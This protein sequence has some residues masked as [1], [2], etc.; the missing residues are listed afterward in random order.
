MTRLIICFLVFIFFCG[1]KNE[2]TLIPK[3]RAYPRVIYP[4]R[5]YTLFDQSYCNFS[6]EYPAYC[7]IE[8][9]DRFFDEAPQDSCWF[10]LHFN[11]FNARLHFSYVPIDAENSFDRLRDDA[12]KLVNKHT[13]KASYIEEIKIDKRSD[14]SGFAFNI[15]GPAASPFQFY[16][17]DSTNNFLRASLYFRNQVNIDSIA[18]VLLFMREDLSHIINTFEWNKK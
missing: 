6:F 10:D 9:Q 12:Y 14:V 2:G 17:T 1:C 4:E 15:E 16:L 18:P 7:D 8:R 13:S 3:P 11:P 5:S